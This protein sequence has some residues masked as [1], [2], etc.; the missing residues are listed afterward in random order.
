MKKANFYWKLNKEYSL[1]YFR[2]IRFKTKMDSMLTDT[3]MQLS[4]KFHR[5]CKLTDISSLCRVHSLNFSG[6]HKISG[7]SSLRHVHSLNLRSC[8]GE[9]DDYSGSMESNGKDLWGFGKS[10]YVRF[11]L[12]LRCLATYLN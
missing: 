5:F 8:V 1:K 11:Q 9:P 2:T 3:K 10:R 4:L 7:V 6:S 12:I